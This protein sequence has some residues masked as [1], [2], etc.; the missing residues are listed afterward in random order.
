MIDI[1]CGR[2]DIAPKRIHVIT[3][4]GHHRH[5]PDHWRVPNTQFWILE[6]DCS[7][8]LTSCEP[9]ISSF[10]EV[11]TRRKLHLFRLAPVFVRLWLQLMVSFCQGSKFIVF[12]Y[13]CHLFYIFVF[14][15]KSTSSLGWHQ[16]KIDLVKSPIVMVIQF[17]YPPPYY[18]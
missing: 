3:S 6:Y 13:H 7:E 12:E 17:D 9:N 8:C 15:C 5:A 1:P 16:L 4:H 14:H 2:F 10:P 11:L 18:V